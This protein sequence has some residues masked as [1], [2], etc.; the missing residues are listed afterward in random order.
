MKRY[1]LAIQ[2]LDPKYVNQLIVALVHQGYSVYYNEDE[3]VVCCTVSEDEVTDGAMSPFWRGWAERFAP[4][5]KVDATFIKRMKRK[6]VE[7]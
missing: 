7:I 5:R 1:E 2:I 3:K 6:G 4:E